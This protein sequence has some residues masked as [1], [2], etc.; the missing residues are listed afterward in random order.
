VLCGAPDNR[1]VQT[2]E[3]RLPPGSS[4]PKL[5]AQPQTPPMERRRGRASDVGWVS[6]LM[7]TMPASHAPAPMGAPTLP[8]G[9]RPS[10]RARF[11]VFYMGDQQRILTPL[12]IAGLAGKEASGRLGV[13]C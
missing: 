6:G 4:E 13:A 11:G 7:P 3:D 1:G 8:L 9:P 10:S 5:P 12:A 2:D